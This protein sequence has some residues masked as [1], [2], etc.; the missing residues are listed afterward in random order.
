MC[1]SSARQSHDF[2]RMHCGLERHFKTDPTET[3]ADLGKI[4]L[5][6]DFLYF[7]V[8]YLLF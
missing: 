7:H 5:K 8:V 4:I 1:C 3:V 6:G 2:D